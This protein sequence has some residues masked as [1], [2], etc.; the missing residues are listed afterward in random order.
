MR[1]ALC[2]L[3]LSALFSSAYASTFVDLGS[4]SCSGTQS[5]D[6]SNVLAF[7]CSG[8]FSLSGGSLISDSGISLIAT[9]HLSLDNFTLSG[10]SI[11]ITADSIDIQ[12]SG[13]LNAPSVTLFANTI[14]VVGQLVT[15]GILQ[16]SGDIRSPNPR[17]LG[18]GG[19]ITLTPPSGSVPSVP[20]PAAFIELLTGL[21]ALVSISKQA[22]G[23]AVV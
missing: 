17:N 3:C 20:L 8:D 13:L 1:Y 9:G 5:F 19:G 4:S 11:G 14:L 21:I 22:R 23:P 10:L 7:S 16:P 2:L 6:G 15:P 12:S 18:G